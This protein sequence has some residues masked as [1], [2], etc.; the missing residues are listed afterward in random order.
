MTINEVNVNADSL[1][2]LTLKI[3]CNTRDYFK[4]NLIFNFVKREKME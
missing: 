3:N 1:E 4:K 2:D